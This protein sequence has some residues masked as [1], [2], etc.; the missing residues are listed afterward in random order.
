M[1]DL[2]TPVQAMCAFPECTAFG[3]YGFRQ[4]GIANLAHRNPDAPEVWTCEGHRAQG[5]AL[6]AA[7]IAAAQ[8]APRGPTLAEIQAKAR[9]DEGLLL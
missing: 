6:L 7:K 8:D 3:C 4:P 1:A 9:R 5:E 2:P